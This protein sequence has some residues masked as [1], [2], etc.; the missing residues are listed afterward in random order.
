VK[1]LRDAGSDNSFSSVT[2]SASSSWA[3]WGESWY[4]H[5]SGEIK[6]GWDSSAEFVG[7][8]LDEL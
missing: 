5:P 8:P 6:K 2:A 1:T 4:G 3:C 7:R